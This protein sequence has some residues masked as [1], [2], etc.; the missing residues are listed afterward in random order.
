MCDTRR[1]DVK[2]SI[3]SDKRHRFPPGIRTH[4]AWRS[5]RLTRS[6]RDVAGLLAERGIILIY[7]T[8]RR[9]C[10]KFGQACANTLR[11]PQPSDKGHLDGGFV[12]INSATHSLCR[13]VD[14]EGNV[15][16][17][18]VQPQRERRAAAR[19]FRTLLTGLWYV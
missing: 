13:A 1:T 12:G 10:R 4:A 6:Y 15:L 19:F 2:T 11:R 16:G 5:F 7:E 8:V 3:P 14:Q 17:I 18:L 9:W